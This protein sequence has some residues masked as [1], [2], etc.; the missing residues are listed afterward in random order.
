MK[1]NNKFEI[2]GPTGFVDFLGIQKLKKSTIEVVF[3]NNL[4]LRGSLNHVI[5]DYDNNE[6]K[7][8]D[9]IIGHKI[10]SQDGYFIVKDIIH[11]NQE[12][13]VY[14]VI[15]SGEL[16]LYYTNGVVSHNCNFLG[17]GDNV[18]DSKLLQKVHETYVREPQNKM[19]GN[20]L[21][22]WKEPVVGHRYVMGVDIS[23]GDSEDFSC[24][25]IIDFDEREQ[26][27]EYVGKLPPDNM[28]EICYKWGSM[29]SAYIVVDITGGMGVSTSRKL[30]EMG[31]KNLYIDG[32]DI[33]NKWKYVP[34]SA[35]KIPGINFNNKRVQ[36]IASYEEALRH[37]FKIYSNRLFNEMNTFVY[38]NGRPDH[39][40][41]HHD[42]LIMSIAMATYVAESSFTNLT[43]VSEQA[44]IM[45]ESWSVSNNDVLNDQLS[46]NPVIPNY[47]NKNSYGNQEVS[48]N[49]YIKYGWLFGRR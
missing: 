1:T 46:F 45:I 23:R 47:G 40:K 31:Y 37:G 10:K 29:Y 9:I 49:D 4:T 43:K 38:I 17:S 25:Q 22:I 6:I 24:F 11:H 20:S 8:K 36:I 32:V 13:D 18:F 30:Q 19:I 41:G 28:A 34:K 7:L 5:F 2:L 3:D 14:D 44:K 27:A 42:D 39:Q 15:N 26:V 33:T 21:W 35:E 16:H 12:S 48:K